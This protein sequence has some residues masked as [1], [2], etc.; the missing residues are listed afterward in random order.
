MTKPRY[1]VL[2]VTAHPDD[3]E[4]G[5]AGTLAKW[6]DDGAE[7][8]ICIVTDGSTGTQ[9]RDLMG[10]RLAEVRRA[11]TER[12]AK[13]VGA[14]ELVWLG[15]EDGYVEYTLELR[16]DIA[17]VFRRFRPHRF[18][19]MD[20]T[21]T[22]D[23]RFINHPDHRA[24]G[25]AAL[26]VSMTAGTTP[27][28]FPELLDEGLV[29]WRGLREVW[30]QGPGLRST[31]VDISATIERKVEALL[32][33]E[34][35]IGDPERVVEWVKQRHAEHG[36]PFGFEYAESFDVITQG[37]GFHPDEQIEEL[38]LARAPVHPPAAPARRRADGSGSGEEEE[39][40]GR[41]PDR[42]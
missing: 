42:G 4:F 1:R 31:G 34:S 10:R 28:H 38:D 17:R 18:L 35:Q 16:R 8:T 20:P 15:H 25:Q 36:H 6:V 5:S 14:S 12:A 2:S 19:V 41:S 32:C 7:L 27:G 26:D 29:P 3:L 21:P 13:I 22:I 23:N 40:P 33:H 9:D 11:E 24:T 37:P 30:I 39:S